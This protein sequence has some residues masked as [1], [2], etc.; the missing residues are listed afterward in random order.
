M[1]QSTTSRTA[2]AA[3]AKAESLLPPQADGL[4][5]EAAG[6]TWVLMVLS[7][8][9]AQLVVLPFLGFLALLSYDF[10][11]QQPG[12]WVAAA[13]LLAGSSAVLRY[14]SGMFVTQIGFS[15][16]LAGLALLV[17]GL[18]FKWNNLTVLVLLAV[19]LGAAQVVRMA[20]VQ[21]VL[22]VL[23]TAVALALTFGSLSS[24]E[25]LYMRMYPSSTLLVALALLWA[26]WCVRE[27]QWSVHAWARRV[28]ALADGVGV[29]L[30]LAAGF[31]SGR[32]YWALNMLGRGQRGSA[33]DPLAGL[34]HILNI[35]W[36][37]A[38]QLA[39]VL[40]AAAWLAVHWQLR[41][42]GQ[43]RNATLLGLVIA[44]LVLACLVV[45]QVGVVALVGTVALGTGRWK[46]LAF[47][48]LTL[49]AQLSG[50]YYALQWPLVHKAVLLAGTG[51]ALALALWALRERRVAAEAA[52]TCQ[53]GPRRWLAPVL[54]ALA[55]AAALGLV[56]RDVQQKEQLIA[57]GQKIYLPLAPRDPRSLMQGDYM[58]LNF[59]FP[60]DIRHQLDEQGRTTLT[61][62]VLVVA[63]LDARGVA[64]VLRVARDGEPLAAGE[65]HLPLK[66]LNGDW[67]LVTDAFYFP[68]GQG[69][70]F[71]RARF[72]EFRALPDGRALLV[73]LADEA[74]HPIAPAP[75]K[76]P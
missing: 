25:V 32:H 19:L 47:T 31:A 21:R 44:V 36:P 34:A 53:A 7:F 26:L 46:L 76:Q 70:P 20:W 28:A 2:L 9:G 71:S 65:R 64:T 39:L 37:T 23:A 72:G 58:A 33:D 8:L 17:V 14:Q 75:R 73:G 40:G 56:H 61:S 50:F 42:R 57:Q 12:V 63:R 38:V 55:A 59:G 43:A 41:E 52:P 24:G 48:G 66:R 15:A 5:G 60:N 27:P 67:A 54:I 35:G 18:D 45:P 16:L 1:T 22:G 13:L 68:E 11:F 6:P 49:L 10:F 69:E 29:A 62:Q 4:A 3:A 51:A 74:L 30:L